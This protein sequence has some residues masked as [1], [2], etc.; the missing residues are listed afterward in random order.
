[1]THFVILTGLKEEY[2]F[3]L[4]LENGCIGVLKDKGD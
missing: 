3:Y 1:M 2:E 4:L